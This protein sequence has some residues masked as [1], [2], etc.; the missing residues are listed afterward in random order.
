MIDYIKDYGITDDQFNNILKELDDNI[1]ELLRLHDGTVKATMNY[2]C[3]L[4]VRNCLANIILKR[5]DLLLIQKK[6]LEDY[7]NKIDIKLFINVLNTNVDD[8]ILIG[9]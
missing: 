1:I 3:D 5:P 8:L 4:G 2:L 6:V 9:I 7:L